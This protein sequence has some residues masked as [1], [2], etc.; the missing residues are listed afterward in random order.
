M[1]Y[2][3]QSVS[4]S[5]PPSWVESPEEKGNNT[6]DSGDMGIFTPQETYNEW[7]RERKYLY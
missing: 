6:P 1:R 3:G 7:E 5:I 4:Y 2:V